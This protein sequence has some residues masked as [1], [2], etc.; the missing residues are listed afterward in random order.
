M[1]TIGSYAVPAASAMEVMDAR[2][3]RRRV[4]VL[5]LPGL[6]LAALCLLP[7]LNKAYTIDDPAFL[8]EARQILRTPLH[9]WSFPF[10]WNGNETCLEQAGN[11]GANVHEGLMGYLLVSVTLAGGPE[12]L[13]HLLQ[14]ILVGLV[15]VEMVWLAVRLG[16][17][18]TEAAFAGLLIVAIAPVLSM[19]STAMPDVLALALGL[20]GM[21]RLQAWK[22]DR[23]WRQGVVA[24]LAL[25]L[26]PYA[27]PHTALFL[28]LA[29]VWLLD[30]L[31]I[32]AALDQ[33][34]KHLRLWWPILLAGL[35]FVGVSFLTRM[36]GG[37]NEQ[38]RLIGTSNAIPNILTF[39]HYLS[40]PIPLTAG[41]VLMRP[42]KAGILLVPIGIL[43][44]A[45]WFMKSAYGET[46]PPQVGFV[47]LLQIAPILAGGA[48]LI[49]IINTNLRAGDK[50][51]LLLSLWILMP[52]PAV[53]YFHFPLKYLMAVLPAIILIMIRLLSPLRRQR[54]FL[55]HAVIVVLCAGY[56]LLLLEADADF[57]EY[58]R[59]ASAELIAPR[60]AA[61]EKVWFSGQW[62][63]YWYAQEAGARVTKPGEP[64]PNPGELLAVGL[65]EGGDAALKRFP[66]RELID[67]RSYDSPHG[68]TM[69]YG[70]GLYSNYYGLLPWRWNP[71]A[72]NQYQLWRVH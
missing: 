8:L 48:M 72:T 22:D 27:R 21:E 12:W 36:K 65:L 40:F 13:A 20:G 46:L 25:G 10:C 32:R 15:V 23:H 5:A 52:L 37:S 57:A 49:D 42:R 30:E 59:R 54:A 9:P 69:G 24:G 7:F 28:P 63:F 38:D 58:G 64:G 26:A 35:V 51:G 2:Q 44:V 31:K 39:F 4:V 43:V 53:I 33:L 6:L 55:A 60:V 16:L 29:A 47:G 14:M 19:A 62:G 11:L 45:V 68:R 3:Q 61:G 66:N 70:A 1:A 34:R 41:W 67:S 18:E 71:A 17:G 56:S 50:M